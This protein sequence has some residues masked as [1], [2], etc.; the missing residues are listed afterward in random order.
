MSFFRKR[1]VAITLCIVMIIGALAIGQKKSQNEKNTLQISS[2]VQQWGRENK[3]AYTRYARDEAGLLDEDTL[4]D[5]AQ[6]NAQSDYA[7]GCICGLWI[8]SD[9]QGQDMEDA[10]FSYADQL[11]LG[12]NDY[13]LLLDASAE[14]WYFA[15]GDAASSY[16]DHAL[17]IL[18]TG[19][20]TAVFSDPDA[21]V[22]KLYDGLSGWYADNLPA[23][24]EDSGN[25]R[26]NVGMV[27]GGSILFIVL[28]GLLIAVS[29]LSAL[30]RAGRRIV[31]GW[32]PIF[33]PHGRRH[34]PGPWMGPGPGPGPR[35]NPGAR[36]HNGTT[37]RPS[38]GAGGFGSGNR[39]N[40]GRGG[41]FGG[42][43]RGGFGGKR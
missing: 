10:A 11:G 14:E 35:P 36:P 17:E 37:S 22:L 27:A 7:Y 6:F 38:S 33:I 20:T 28:I 15:F 32:M 19:S 26:T 2:T 18:V 4:N 8:A 3:A 16:V 34:G 39:G 23:T 1:W 24:G 40:F 42:G 41:G 31:G 29:L 21:S 43:N 13:I 12:E 5:L 9:L 30:M 25:A